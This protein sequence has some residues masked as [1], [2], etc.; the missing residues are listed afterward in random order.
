MPP[1]GITH[2]FFDIGGVLGSNGWDREQRAL[3][4]K[5]FGLEDEVEDRHQEVSSEFEVGRLDLAGYLECT[6]FFRERPFSRDQFADFMRAQSVPYADAIALA[7]KLASRSDLAL[8]TMNNESEALNLHRI[9]QFGLRGIFSAF[10]S[11]CWLDERKPTLRYF[12]RVLA[13]TQV[14]PAR[15]VF[16]DDRSQNLEPAQRL[17]M[18]TILY[19]DAAQLERELNERTLLQPA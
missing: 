2:V 8:M 7:R 1:Q 4:R 11:S 5:H 19:H 9:R 17:G 3:A 12:H 6:V 13:L 18:D 16:I 14:E 15:S 10:L